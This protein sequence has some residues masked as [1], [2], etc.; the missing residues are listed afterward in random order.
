MTDERS[1]AVSRNEVVRHVV[2][3]GRATPKGLAL[4]LGHGL[5]PSDVRPVLESLAGEGVLRREGEGYE[6][7][8]VGMR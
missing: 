8:G 5:K 2:K 3:R 1:V 7:A 4:E 6:L